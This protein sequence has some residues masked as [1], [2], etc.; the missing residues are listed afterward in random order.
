MRKNTK[1][2]I[3]KLMLGI[4]KYQDLELLEEFI[5]ASNQHTTLIRNSGG[6]A[7]ICVCA[8]Y[9]YPNV[10]DTISDMKFGKVSKETREK[11]F[12]KEICILFM[13]SVCFNLESLTSL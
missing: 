11:V 2:P 5:P 7:I 13:F 3:Q 1:I 10:M 9:L 12:V 6:Q 4:P 8:Y